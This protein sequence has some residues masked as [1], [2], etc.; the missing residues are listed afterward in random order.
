MAN[1]FEMEMGN[2]L[3]SPMEDVP[4]EAQVQ[5]DPV[6]MLRALMAEPNIAAKLPDDQLGKIGEQVV[7]EYMI[8]DASRSDW[9]ERVDAA[10]DLA[11]LVADEKNYPFQGAANIKYPL[12]TTAALQFNARAYPAIVSGKK[13]VKCQTWGG[14]PQGL[15]AARAKR[16]SEHMS[17]QLLSE[18]PEWE[19]ETDKLLVIVPIVGCCFRKTYYDPALKRTCS[20]LVMADRFVVNYRARSLN[21]VPRTTEEMLLY[22]YEIEERIRSGRFTEFEYANLE[23]GSEEEETDSETASAGGDD[24]RPHMFLEQHRLLDLDEDGYPEPYIVTV[25]KASSKVVRIVANFSPETVTLND[26]GIVSIRK[27]DYYTKYGFLP[28]PDGGFYE[29]GFGWLLKDIGESINTS[30]NQML[31]AGHVANTQGGLVSASL[32][33]REKKIR[34]SPGEWKVLQTSAPLNQSVY[35]INYPGPSAVLFNLLGLLIDAGREVANVKDVLTGDQPNTAP[36]TTTLALIE[37][38]MQVFNSIYKRIHRAFK[39]ELEIHA[40]INVAN[41]SAEE[42]TAFFDDVDGETG[43]PVPYDPAKDYDLSDMDVMPVSDPQV[44]S[45]AQELARAQ[46]LREWSQGNPLA[47][48]PEV[49]KRVLEAAQIEDVDKLISVPQP[50]PLEQIMQ[51]LLLKNAV[52]DASTKEADLDKKDAEITE[53]LTKAMENIARA[54]GQEEGQQIGRYTA[55]LNA[56]KAQRQLEQRDREIEQRGIQGVA[57][58]SGNPVGAGA[59]SPQ[60]QGGGAGGQG[61]PVQPN[62]MQPGG[63]GGI[64]GT[65]GA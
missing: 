17:Y 25:H 46:F 15:K 54:E 14:D 56:Y 33:L 21:D 6:G 29:M 22:P 5:A 64:A 61:I 47:N 59:G 45:R 27:R 31:D 4:E 44:A 13:V 12:L 23:H 9:K 40:E 20:R 57:G 53:T 58:Q 55:I 41:V 1:A 43:Q 8:D 28:S 7:R 11:M 49:Q 60:G 62:G 48:Q 38:G 16:V 30:L 2:D 37:Q 63:M 3:E 65:N 26:R 51:E 18:I 32:G 34:L 35:P 50:D 19:E 52:L 36:A 24:D 10:M 39:K 42:Y